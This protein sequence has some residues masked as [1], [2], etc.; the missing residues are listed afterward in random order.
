MLPPP[1]VGK[2]GG[3]GGGAALHPCGE[4]AH[5]TLQLGTSRALQRYTSHERTK[6]SLSFLDK[7]DTE[8]LAEDGEDV[9]R[10][11]GGGRAQ[12]AGKSP[13]FSHDNGDGCTAMQVLNGS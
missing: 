11:E 13:N 12:A 9:L 6:P 8:G 7:R 10:S 5:I 3:L 4:G 1:T 2:S